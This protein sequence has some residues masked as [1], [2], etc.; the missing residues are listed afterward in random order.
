MVP[1]DAGKS[2][3]INT[4]EEWT[5]L[6]PISGANI[7][8]RLLREFTKELRTQAIQKTDEVLLG[9]LSYIEL[10]EDHNSMDG[11][12]WMGDFLL[13]ELMINKWLSQWQ[14][15][16]KSRHVNLE[17]DHIETLYRDCTP[18]ELEAIRLNMFHRVS[19]GRGCFALDG[20]CELIN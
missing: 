12:I 9:M 20:R 10:M 8:E 2:E 5:N 13:A 15:S 16:G 18:P 14:A 11:A 1:S 3:V 17:L 4:S 6:D 7:V 19:E